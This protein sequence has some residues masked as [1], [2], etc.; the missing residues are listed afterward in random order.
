MSN[1]S[2]RSLRTIFPGRTV[3]ARKGGVSRPM[4][5][6]TKDGIVNRRMTLF[7]Y[8]CGKETDIRWLCERGYTAA[9]W[10]PAHCPHAPLIVSD[11]VSL[12]FVLNVIK[13]LTERAKAL[14]MSYE[15]CRIALVVAVRRGSISDNSEPCGDGYYIRHRKTFQK[16]YLQRELREFIAV[17][18]SISHDRIH[19]V[20]HGIFYVFKDANAE[21]RY[22]AAR[23][24][25]R[26][27]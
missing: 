3:T 22:L 13:E 19:A 24:R 23:A 12:L 10:D 8:G 5:R 9:G 20:E 2:D 27:R 14:I 6:M 26:S 4:R 7:D 21:K 15:L 1:R 16:I 17:T 11:V 25:Q 18:L